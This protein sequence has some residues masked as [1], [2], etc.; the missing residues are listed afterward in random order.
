MK[1]PVDL[2]VEER[3]IRRIRVIDTIVR[4]VKMPVK[5]T[6]ATHPYFHEALLRTPGCPAITASTA[7]LPADPKPP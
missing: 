1:I 3:F 7:G 4:S 6:V 5:H 2:V